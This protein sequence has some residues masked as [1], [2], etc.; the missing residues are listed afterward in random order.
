MTSRAYRQ[1][2]AAT[3]GAVLLLL[4]PS[5]APAGEVVSLANGIRATIY[6]A[7][8]IAR[9]WTSWDGGVAVLDHPAGANVELATNNARMVPFPAEQVTAALEAMHGFTTR[10]DVDVFILPASPLVAGKSFARRGAIYLAPGTGPVAPST[11]AYIVTH[12]MGHVLTWARIDDHPSR[13][14]AYLQLRGLD[15]SSLDQAAQ[16]ADR[17]REILAEDIRHLFGGALATASG[18]IENHDLVLPDRVAGLEA[19][20]AGYFAAAGPAARAVVATAFPNP[21]NPMTTIEMVLPDATTA[22]LVEAVLDIYD[23]RGRRITVLTGGRVANDRVA[24]S[25]NGTDGA[26][27]AAASGRYLY[28]MRVGASVGRGSVTLVR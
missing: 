14:A 16:H 11:I 18:S 10:I 1:M 26:G 4:A 12:E 2:T 19:L 13:W 17:A 25:W 24:L 6:T 20:L 27:N 3:L 8:E 21:C 23:V 15:A 22:G 28:V 9:D 7:A 5:F